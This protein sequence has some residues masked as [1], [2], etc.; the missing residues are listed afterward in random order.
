MDPYQAA[1]G[2]APSGGKR[3]HEGDY[4]EQQK[5]L[6]QED[7]G[8]GVSQNPSRVVLVQGL[9]NDCLESEL[10]ALVGPFAAVEKCILTPSKNEALVQLPDLDASTNL[11]N[12]YRSRDAL[13]RGQK[14][15]FAFSSRDSLT[16][17]SSHTSSGPPPS[18]S[19]SSRPTPSSNHSSRNGPPPSS[20]SHHPSNRPPSSYD[21]QGPPPS[22]HND[23][24]PSSYDQRPPSSFDQRP[25]SSSY[26]QRGPPPSSYSDRNDSRNGP[27]YDRRPSDRGGPA[28][29]DRGAP[30]PSYDRGAPPPSYDRGAPSSYDRGAPP[31]SYDRGGPPS[32]YDRGGPPAYTDRA[33]YND[34]R[35][36]PSTFD[37]T[38][39]PPSSSSSYER[40]G[41]Q[42]GYPPSSHHASGFDRAPTFSGKNT[43]LMVTLSKM[44]YDVNVDVLHQVFS[45]YGTVMKVVTFYQREEFKALVQLQT[46]EQAEAAQA[47]LDGRDIY[48]GCNTLHIQMSTHKSLNVQCNNDKM[49]DYFNPHLPSHDPAE[50]DHIRGMLG[51]MPPPPRQGFSPALNPIQGPP[52]RGRDG[53]GFGGPPPHMLGGGGP[54]HHGGPPAPYGA[55]QQGGGPPPYGAA[56]PHYDDRRG[57][58]S[59][60]RDRR[61]RSRDRGFGGPPPPPFRDEYR[62]PP[63]SSVLICSN[64]DPH[65]VK[66]QSLFT[67]FG[68]FGDVLRIKVM[69]RKNDTALVQFVDEKHATSA[70]EL[71]DGMVLCNKKLRV[72]FSKHTAVVMPRPDADL[73]EVQNTRDFTNTPYHRY[74][75]RSLAE[76]CPPSTLLHISG[77]PVSMQLQPGDTVST[78]RLLSMFAEW[79]VVK[80]YHPI[81]KQPKMVLL[82]MGTLEE[83]FDAMIALDNYTFNDGRIRVSFSKSYQRQ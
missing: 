2:G 1:S 58:R 30:P 47:A 33:P 51:D 32:S 48:T 29:Y 36:G 28:P 9:P 14:V 43:I 16:P 61:S 60:S 80:K 7:G 69:F 21:R 53:G 35:G 15:Q 40:G 57:G 42:Q 64:L 4:H 54:P 83:A 75:K 67:M 18:Q 12:F 3:Q 5:R 55:P 76:V 19:A 79:G 25:P 22:H 78:S 23:R 41:P 63:R 74:R 24:P 81:A 27:S 34:P 10:L 20:S 73:F 46:T 77:I 59:R 50:K 56:P 31:P 17:T 39:P 70:R 26:D 65:F 49:R 38:G 44:D 82:E 13:V 72:D 66:V 8:S 62:G 37:R 68:C 6:R 52:S 45:K 71:M 11:V